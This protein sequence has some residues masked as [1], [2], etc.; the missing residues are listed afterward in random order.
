MLYYPF[1][2][3]KKYLFFIIPLLCCAFSVNSQTSDELW[4]QTNTFS[5]SLSS[6]IQSDSNPKEFKVFNL[7]LDLFKNR[8]N[9]SLKQVSNK[10][11]I[12]T[13]ISF[14]NELGQL[15][16]YE[17]FEASVMS[18]KLQKKYPTIKSYIGNGVENSSLLIRFSITTQGLNAIILNNERGTIYIEPFTKDNKSYKVY[19]SK[20]LPQ[21]KSFDCKVEN[22]KNKKP[23]SNFNNKNERF[24]D[25][26][27]R[28]YRL[29][30]STTGEYSQWHLN[31]QEISS[32]ESNEKKKEVVL[33]SIISTLTNVNAIYERDLSIRLILVDNN[34]EIIFL[35]SNSDNL[36]N[37]NIGILLNEN[38]V[39]CDNLIGYNNYDIG[40]VLSLGDYGGVAYGNSTCSEFKAGGVS[41]ASSPTGYSFE[42]IMAHEIGHQFGATHTFNSTSCSQNRQNITAVEPGSGSTIMAYAGLC[43]PQNIQMQYDS[44]FHFVSINQIWDYINNGEGNCGQLV[45]I[46]N[47]APESDQLSNYSL[48]NSTPFIL[49]IHAT[50]SDNDNLTY[51][52]EQLNNEI[53]ISPPVS[54]SYV[55]ALFRSLPP[56]TSSKRYFPNLNTVLNGSLSSKW[57]VLPSV[58]REA[59]FGVTIRDNNSE[60]GQTTSK[61]TILHFTGNSV[62][63]KLNSQK[64]T[65]TW[66]K[67]ESKI[68]NWE[69]ANTNITPV[70][71]QT[72]NILF[73]HDGGQTFP[74]ALASGVVN[75]GSYTIIAP[76]IITFEGRIKIESVGNIFYAINCK[77]IYIRPDDELDYDNDGVINTLDLCPNTSIGEVVNENGCSQNQL[78]F[79]DDGILNELDNCLEE[80]N[81]DQSDIDGDKI[82][83]V[84]D[85]DIDGDEINNEMDNCSLISN[86]FQIDFDNDGIGDNCDDDIDND[87]VLNEFDV[88]SYSPLGNIVDENGCTEN[89]NTSKS[90]LWGVSTFG[91]STCKGSIFK[92]NI[93]TD[94]VEKIFEFGEDQLG[95]NPWANLM[96]A[97]NGKLYGMTTYGG[98]FTKGVLYEYNISARKYTKLI[99][100][101]GVNKGSEP[102]GELMQASNGKLYGMTSKGG[103]NDLG[104]LFEYD[105]NTKKFEKKLDF[106]GSN[107]G[108]TPEY[109]LIEPIK[110]R[111]FGTILSGGVHDSGVLFEFNYITEK[112][113][114]L[115]D[116]NA[117]NDAITGHPRA[118]IQAS[119]GKIYGRTT[120]GGP[121]YNGGIFEYDIQSKSF[122]LKVY[123]K[124]EGIKPYGGSSILTEY[125]EG[126]F[127]SLSNEGGA[128]STGTLFMYDLESNQIST[129]I[130]LENISTGISP[131]NGLFKA[132]NGLLYGTISYGGEK[133]NGTII[134][135]APS[136]NSFVK[137]EDFDGVNYGG[138]P[139]HNTF[140]EINNY[141]KDSDKDGII[142]G[143]DECPNTPSNEEVEASGCSISQDS[144][145]DGVMNNLDLCPNTPENTIIDSNGCF[146][147]S[148]NNFTIEVTNET[149]PN[150]NN[151]QIKIEATEDYNYIATING[152]ELNFTNTKAINDLEP[153]TYDMC[154]TIPEYVSYKQ[155]YSIDIKEGA[156]ISAKSSTTSN[157][158]SIDIEKGTAPFNI[159]INGKETYKTMSSSF[160][161]DVNH[162]DLVEIKT[163]VLCEGIYTKTINLQQT[164]RAFPNPTTG[165]FE[166]DLPLYLNKIKIDLFTINS[167]LILTKDY[168]VTQGKVQ[169]NIENLPSAVYI[170]KVHLENPVSIKII[171]K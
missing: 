100:F 118:I 26:Y 138:S 99:D 129:K 163:D 126:V 19:S 110:G 85:N 158:I 160:K 164:L 115:I 142:D 134:S 16:K 66:F 54:N 170:A 87:G 75:N 168:L 83:D 57:E 63:F 150:K 117:D 148:E 45:P 48:P 153:G 29:A 120:V 64:T 140:I 103:T 36:T 145:N 4:F 76:D 98:D 56:S 37:N 79:D 165:V 147:M 55:G 81:P 10:K 58:E 28:K 38:Q 77:N 94:V 80:S 51:T 53:S 78:D 13:I 133:D 31:K 92:L 9:S 52:W 104:I 144:D 131:I 128:N 82:G 111:L 24:N 14:P 125:S 169:I 44:Y 30:V 166:I 34:A 101:D 154:F 161:L 135:Y 116:F 109:H 43:S 18:E 74:I 65:E 8:L 47:K 119:N 155:C 67:G 84:C 151:G 102:M 171:K 59:T 21:R 112:F 25:G 35:N 60:S 7:N 93:K 3:K 5:K 97:F 6:K 96:Q 1:A 141:H 95:T 39:V 20:L 73:S 2:M 132:S 12:G 121:T 33:S 49:D 88:C 127:Y 41:S 69:V 108:S 27:L 50:D 42:G 149:C 156:T 106:D 71:C 130:D 22:F 137:I 62:P 86:P 91:S 32:T 23:S 139:Q 136:T 114:K 159:F 61:E 167:Q 72:V 122:N 15:Q 146:I 90:E 105:I 17:V 11:K 143:Y 70:N 162:G 68:I 124:R 152:T 157:K 40:H 123:F 113:T 46:N 107:K 89:Q